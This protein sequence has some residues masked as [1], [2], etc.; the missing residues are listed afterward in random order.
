MVLSMKE[1][2]KRVFDCRQ[3]PGGI[4][5]H[6]LNKKTVPCDAED[7]VIIQKKT[8]WEKSVFQSVPA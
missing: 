8:L 4:L 1:R 7:H 5:D 3:S 2:T 6:F